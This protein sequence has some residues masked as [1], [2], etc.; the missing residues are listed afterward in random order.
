MVKLRHWDL[1]CIATW[2]KSKF[3]RNTTQGQLR[4]IVGEIKEWRDAVGSQHKLEE[5]ADVYIASAG[6][7]RFGELGNIGSFICQI[8]QVL[9]SQGMETG[10]LQYAVDVKMREN[11]EREFDENM[12]HVPQICKR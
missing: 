9:D 4:K 2:N 11:V 5:L 1:L 6:L 10:R 3:P 7:T 12:Q 8:L